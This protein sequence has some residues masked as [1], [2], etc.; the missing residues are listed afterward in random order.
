VIETIQS[1]LR[2]RRRLKEL[3]FLLYPKRLTRQDATWIKN[4][5]EGVVW[6]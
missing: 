5:G 1:A 3:R 4:H 2:R 6:L